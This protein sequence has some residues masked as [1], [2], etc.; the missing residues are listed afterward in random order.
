MIKIQSDPRVYVIARH[1]ILR[2]VPSEAVARALYGD[3]W[4]HMIDDVPDS[5]F[6][7]YILGEP[8]PG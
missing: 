1:G 3:D 4:R 2:L 6:V 5:F 7:N 8:L